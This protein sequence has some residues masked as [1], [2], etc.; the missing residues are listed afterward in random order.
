MTI[1]P[2]GATP[3]TTASTTPGLGQPAATTTDALPTDQLGENT[4]L[5]LMV[6][7]L[8]NQDPMNPTDST[9]FL[10]QTAQFTSLEKLEEVV[11]QN[12]QALSTQ[13]SFG[14]SGLVGRTV[15]FTDSN[16]AAQTG[17][18]AGVRFT[19]DGPILTVSDQ[20]VPISDVTG[21]TSTTS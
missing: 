12:A 19:P 1:S 20:D 5:Q 4:F 2:I 17:T 6:A 13:M 21:V 7:Q 9:Q 14:A 11:N 15:T 3:T 8:R 16:G 18:V 10:A